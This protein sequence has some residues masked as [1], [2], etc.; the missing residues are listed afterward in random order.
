IR[1]PVYCLA[2]LFVLSPAMFSQVPPSSH[3]VLVMEE[4]HGYSSVISNAAMPY[5]NLLAS[6]YGL[7]LQ[8]YA[9][10]HNSIPNYLMLTSGQFLTTNDGSTSV[11]SNDNLVRRM[12]AGGKTW[13]SYAESLPAVGYLGADVYPYAR[14]HNPFVY[15]SDVVNSAIQRQNVV[16][17]TQFATDLANGGLPDFSYIVP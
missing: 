2:L 3:V 12:G 4:N 9:N 16:P 10:A 7:A 17:F 14:R 1:P 15:Y 11:F 8:Y 6:S 13:K 5:L